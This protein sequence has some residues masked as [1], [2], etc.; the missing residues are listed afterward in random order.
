MGN[1]VANVGYNILEATAY[2]WPEA[3]I[4]KHVILTFEED[5]TQNE[6]RFQAVEVS[7]C[8]AASDVANMSAYAIGQIGRSV[9][10]P[11]VPSPLDIDVDRQC[12][13]LI[14]LDPSKN[15]QFTVDQVPCTLKEEDLYGN[16]IYLRHVYQDSKTGEKGAVKRDGCK[17]IFFGVVQRGGEND[18]EKPEPGRCGINL[19]VEFIQDDG[20]ITKKLKLIID[21]DVPNDGGTTIP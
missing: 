13:L 10:L 7:Q 1:N 5:G 15:W 16:N 11:A 21:P 8:D 14:Q 12:W 20:S 19:N 6:L 2:P 9:P 3:K 17:T 18:C 4:I